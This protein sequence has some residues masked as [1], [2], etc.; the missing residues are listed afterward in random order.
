MPT[1]AEQAI[2]NRAR[3]LCRAR[4]FPQAEIIKCVADLVTQILREKDNDRQAD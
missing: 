2:Y 4:G 3:A 1:P